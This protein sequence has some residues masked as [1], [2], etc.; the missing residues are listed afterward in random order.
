MC[1]HSRGVQL[2]LFWNIVLVNE[3]LVLDFELVIRL[4]EII[5]FF[6]YPG[7]WADGDNLPSSIFLKIK[8]VVK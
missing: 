7:W 1:L 5:F 8:Y 4:F 2:I 6:Y 3:I